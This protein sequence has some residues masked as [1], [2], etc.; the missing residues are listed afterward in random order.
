MGILITGASGLIGKNFIRHALGEGQHIHAL[1]RNVE[2]FKMLPSAQV[3]GWR[4]DQPVPPQAWDN[5]DAVIHLSGEGIAEK[6]WSNQQKR[7][8]V[9][10]RIQGTKN[11]V[12]SIGNLPPEKRP[13]VLVS[14]SAIG[15][16]GYHQDGL[17]D[18]SSAPGT[19]FLADLCQKWEQEALV[20]E[21]LGVRVVLLRTGIVLSREGGALAKMPPLQ[22]SDGKSWMSWI[23]IQDMVRI[24]LFSLKNKSVSGPINCVAPQP[25][26]NKEFVQ[27]LA[28]S[29]GIY[30]V[31]FV[32]KAFL[33][34]ALG[35]M[36]KAIL[37]DLRIRSKV[38][39][40]AGF[41]FLFP[42]LKS[43]L[44]T[45]FQGTGLFDSFL[46]KDQFVP[47][48]PEE[49]FQFFSRAE[50][51]EI[52]T[53]PWLNFKIISKSS[54][55]MNKG[56]IIDYKLKIHGLP[57]YWKTLIADWKENESFVDQQVKGPYSKW[58][59][60]H[61]FDVVPGGCLLRDQVTYR[62]PVAIL[63]NILLG[64]WIANDVRKIFEYRQKKIQS[65]LKNG[66]FR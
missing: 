53:P 27:E 25:V 3:F 22:I 14:G 58:H 66:G 36:S 54:D 17:L 24:L 65:L 61:T 45:E 13:K 1:V 59:H 44:R 42:D 7:Q 40:G 60:L 9:E 52:L 16:Y 62:V 64:Q 5:I 33:S 51:L 2:G 56:T 49:I 26:Q 4:H 35:E 29:K 46:F 30:S 15:F 63:G 11:L 12:A 38:L 55:E 43:A 10:S 57:V 31:G 18:E 32:P 37:S 21:K 23:H 47:L 48:K 6:R 28:R 19:D 20:A 34:L 39:V 41:E 50:N 8:L